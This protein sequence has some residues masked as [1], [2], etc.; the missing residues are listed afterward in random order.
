[1]TSYFNVWIYILKLKICSYI[2]FVYLL[3]IV[4]NTFYFIFVSIS[5][6][7]VYTSVFYFIFNKLFFF[8]ISSCVSTN[9]DI[10]FI[11]YCNYWMASYEFIWLC[12]ICSSWLNLGPYL[13]LVFELKFSTGLVLWLNWWIG[14]WGCILVWLNWKLLNL[15][16]S[17]FIDDRFI[18][19]WYW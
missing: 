13:Y 4:G 14:V 11:F 16:E 18:M 8:K 7:C 1:M 6:I 5:Y 17:G 12:G 3:I 19:S 10:W 9:C 15:L 2:Y